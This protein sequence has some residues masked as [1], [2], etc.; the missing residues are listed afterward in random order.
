MNKLF[1]DR[2]RLRKSQWLEHKQDNPDCF[3]DWESYKR[4]WL[5]CTKRGDSR[6]QILAEAR[7]IADKVERKTN[8]N[9]DTH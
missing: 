1:E 8:E 4:V 6:Q 2:L 7:R 3:V 9:L 5:T